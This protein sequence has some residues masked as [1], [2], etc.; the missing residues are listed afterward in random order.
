VSQ[1]LPRTASPSARRREPHDL[2]RLRLTRPAAA[3]LCAA[4]VTGVLLGAARPPLDL[5][6][7]A[8]VAFVPLFVAWR[9]RGP[10]AAAG[11]AF[12]AAVVY[13][14][15][16]LSWTWY[17]GTVAIVPL[18]LVLAAYWAAAGAVV[19]W[20][21]RRHL[22]SPFVVAGVWV[23]AEAAVARGPLG[24]F[25]W[26][27]VGYAF[28]DIVAGRALASDGGVALVS[29][30]AVALNGFL[31]EAF[32]AMRART[33]TDRRRSGFLAAGLVA[34]L[35]L[36][37]IAI[38]ARSEPPATGTMR[39]AI[40]QGNDKN[41]DLTATEERDRYLPRSHF[42]LA[43][44]VR[45]P[46]DLIVF[47]ESS[48]DADPRTDPFLRSHLT[49]VARRNHAWVLANAVADAPAHGNRPAGAKVLNLDVLY[50]PD[51]TL[52]G[53]YSKRHLVPFGEYIPFRGLLEGRVGAIDRVPRDFEPG[54]SPGLFDVAGHRIATIICF[55][56]AFGYQ[57]RPLVRDGAQVIIVSTN[58]RSYERSANS[59]QHV[60]I[61]QMR[62]A[63]T[64]RPLVQAAISG[65]SA[66][67][68]ADGRVT[69]R[70]GLFERRL[71]EATVTATTG[72]TPYVRYGEWAI[73]LSAII[74][75][76]AFVVA[77]RR[78]RRARSIESA[79]APGDEKISADDRIAEYKTVAPYRDPPEHDF[80]RG[81]AGR[82]ASGD[83]T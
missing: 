58:N 26:G 43:A 83:S 44:D 36:P 66:V 14:A 71:L 74:V 11:Y 28:H 41:R 76:G 20:L 25:S 45:D 3:R 59:A 39:V 7:L 33:P 38:A 1:L 81:T 77:V 30:F 29:F 64:G 48:M 50:R 46:V 5:G 63:E 82:G 47:P 72:E 32:L 57:V 22:A 34:V 13:H 10:R 70:T 53:T 16:L 79:R 62:A 80:S 40:L 35:V 60:A 23:L 78:N 27:E 65:I 54:R 2:P 4:A 17:F 31:A 73:E 42:A 12:V 9:D 49:A 52:E 56:S 21:G 61:G 15:W 67:I 69:T 55:E 68:D 51:G 18:V 37:F 6:P 75:I 8:C 24:G 19:G